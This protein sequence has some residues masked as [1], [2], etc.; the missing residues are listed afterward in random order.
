[1]DVIKTICQWAW[2]R[3]PS[4]EKASS[5]ADDTEADDNSDITHVDSSIT[6]QNRKIDDTDYHETKIQLTTGTNNLLTDNDE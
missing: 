2:F 3:K 1:M 6:K 5:E 4:P